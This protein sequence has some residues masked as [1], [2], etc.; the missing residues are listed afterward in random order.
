MFAHVVVVI[1]L[2]GFLLYGVRRG[3]GIP[4]AEY[5]ANRDRTSGR[6]V[7]FS[8]VGTC[9]GG[10]M[11]FGVTAIGYEAGVVGYAIGFA[12][13]VGLVMMGLLAPVA[14]GI[15]KEGSCDIVDDVVAFRYGEKA[16]YLISSV[17]LVVLLAFI[18]SQ[19]IALQS[20]L[21]VVGGRLAPWTVVFGVAV[22]VFYTGLAG[23]AGVVGTDIVQFL[24][25]VLGS[26]VLFVFIAAKLGVSTLADVPA[27]YFTGYGPVALGYGKMFVIGAFAFFA[28]SLL[29]RTDLWQRIASAKDA[30]KARWALIG[31]APVMLLGYVVFTTIGIYAR[32]V[33]GTELLDK[34]QTAKAGMLLFEHVLKRESSGTL[35]TEVVFSAVVLGV[36]GAVMSTAD[37]F[38]NLLAETVSKARS[39]GLW[40]A[41][42]S[43]KEPPERI[44][45][46][47]LCQWLQRVGLVR[48]GTLE[49]T[50]SERRLLK[51]LRVLTVAGALASV[52]LALSVASIVDLIVGSASALMIFTPAVVAGILTRHPNR[53]A[54]LLSMGSGITVYATLIV[55]GLVTRGVYDKAAFVPGVLVAILGYVIGLGIFKKEPDQVS[56]TSSDTPEESQLKEP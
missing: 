21:S 47:P 24:F 33:F 37:S 18:A 6:A 4:L 31:A 9:L 38:L 19:V 42:N 53:R 50:A 17:N 51:E 16:R 40:D 41:Y 11:F 48:R 13:A 8:I 14:K 25:F 22:V 29:V 56:G 12:Y 55:V 5:V 26:V 32:A 35:L 54:G 49:R 34:R 52:I 3:I 27:E 15:A 39:R 36:F 20:L 46:S 10:W 30:S 1:A 23:Y 28:P 7:F 45:L 44:Q 43:G 2:I